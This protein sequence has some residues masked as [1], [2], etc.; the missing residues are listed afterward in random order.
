MNTSVVSTM[1]PLT[2][3]AAGDAISLIL[4]NNG[5]TLVLYRVSGFMNGVANTQYFLQF[6]AATVAPTANTKP[7]WQE[8]VLGVDGFTFDY[9]QKGLDFYRMGGNAAGTGNLICCVSTT[10]GVFTAATTQTASIEVEYESEGYNVTGKSVAG[11]LTTAIQQLSVWISG[12]GYKNLFAINAT[13]N[14]GD[15]SVQ[16]LMLFTSAG[17]AVLG[18]VPIQQWQCA[19]GATLNLDFGDVGFVPFTST[20]ITNAAPTISKGCLLVVSSTSGTYTQ[21]GGTPWTIRAFYK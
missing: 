11:D 8:Q 13:N 7:L 6:F 4:A 14:V 1:K 5:R 21:A 3:Q 17:Q 19:D 15:T 18:A 12:A 10:S 2:G 16:Y 9:S 20:L